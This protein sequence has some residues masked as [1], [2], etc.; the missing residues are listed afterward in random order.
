MGERDL[1]GWQTLAVLALLVMLA[2]GSVSTGAYFWLNELD[3][4]YRHDAGTLSPGRMLQFV[5]QADD[6]GILLLP[7]GG[8]VVDRYGPRRALLLG[9]T[10]V[11]LGGILVGALPFTAALAVLLTVGTVRSVGVVLPTTTMANHR[12]RRRAIGIAVLQFAGTGTALAASLVRGPVGRS[13]TIILGT[14]L[15]ITGLSVARAARNRPEDGHRVADGPPNLSGGGAERD[16]SWREAVRGR[17]FWLLVLAAT[18]LEVV[19]WTGVTLLPELLQERAV[20]AIGAD[21]VVE[22]TEA[23]RQMFTTYNVVTAGFVL[24][25]GV[26]AD[27]VSVRGGLRLFALVHLVAIAALL[28]AGSLTMFFAAVVL[29]ATG[30]GGVAAA[31]VAVLGE[32]FGRR[33][34]ATLLG[35]SSLCI[36]ML[37]RGGTLLLALLFD[38]TDDSIVII[39]AAAALGLAAVAAYGSVENPRPDP[40]RV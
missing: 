23:Y 39:A 30:G 6:L 40:S 24:V 32:Y 12:F 16:H 37:S 13:P 3:S 31:N 27:R 2:A 1:Q 7:L 36:G 14:V 26:A 9:T 10:L 5:M 21:Q 4:L 33:R 8:W 34:F 25:G 20:L 38:T 17:A 18:C 28:T 19:R 22:T 35:T 29:F 11:G 15:L